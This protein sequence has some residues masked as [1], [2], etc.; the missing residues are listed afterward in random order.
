MLSLQP[1]D[2]AYNWVR[3]AL[4]LLKFLFQLLSYLLFL[5]KFP[6]Q[7]LSYFLCLLRF[8]SQI[9][10]TFTS[11]KVRRESGNGG[12]PSRNNP[13]VHPK[14]RWGHHTGLTTPSLHC[15]DLIPICLLLH[16]E[17][18]IDLETFI[19]LH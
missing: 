10:T 14:H 12:M 15:I 17:A 6:S 19:A 16:L 11:A 7:L 4:C 8:S 3:F 18:G 1:R 2:P 13:D 9:S 5:L